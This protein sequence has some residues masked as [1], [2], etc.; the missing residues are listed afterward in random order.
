MG[1]LPKFS[2]GSCT[3]LQTLP[4]SLTKSLWPPE[5]P[6]CRSGLLKLPPKGTPEPCPH[7]IPSI[8]ASLGPSSSCLPES[9]PHISW[10][11]HVPLRMLLRAF[12]LHLSFIWSPCWQDNDLFLQISRLLFPPRQPHPSPLYLLGTHPTTSFNH[13]FCSVYLT[14]DVFVKLFSQSI[15][16]ISFPVLHQTQFRYFVQFISLITFKG[17]NEKVKWLFLEEG[18]LG[19]KD[20]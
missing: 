6:C 8:V 2:E 7:W 3:Q 1:F 12:L 4:R 17:S 9:Y 13:C 11:L 5:R 10:H 15:L 19:F 16:E 14:G 20:R 18:N